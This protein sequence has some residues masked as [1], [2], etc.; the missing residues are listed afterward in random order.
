MCSLIGNMHYEY[1][2]LPYTTSLG[3]VDYEE[4]AICHMRIL[5]YA[6]LY[7]EI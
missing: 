5:P 6:N 3:R 4:V 2:G 1:M 7:I